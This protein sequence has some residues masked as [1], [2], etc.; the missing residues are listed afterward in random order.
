LTNKPGFLYRFTLY[1]VLPV[2]APQKSANPYPPV[3]AMLLLA[4]LQKGS[5]SITCAGMQLTIIM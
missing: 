3:L 4:N 2:Y 5:Q 1:T